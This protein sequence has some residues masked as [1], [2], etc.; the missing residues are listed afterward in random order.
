MN[1]NQSVLAVAV[2]ASPIVGEIA[3]NKC[4]SAVKYIKSFHSREFF[5]QQSYI[6][7]SEFP[8]L[9]G[10]KISESKSI[11]QK[12]HLSVEMDMLSDYN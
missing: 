7:K 8:L 2:S 4:V 3:C 9:R 5:Q 11:G 10:S 12:I 1:I 6:E